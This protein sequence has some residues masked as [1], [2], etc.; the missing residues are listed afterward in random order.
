MTRIRALRD[1]LEDIATTHFDAS[2][3]LEVQATALA[4]TSEGA[5]LAG[6][7]YTARRRGDLAYDARDRAADF[8][9][10]QAGQ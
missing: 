10:R 3:T 4:G 1:R 5:R 7:V 8:D 9:A 6:E 2:N